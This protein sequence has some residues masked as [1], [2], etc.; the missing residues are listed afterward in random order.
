MANN[1]NQIHEASLSWEEQLAMKLC[2]AAGTMMCVY[3]FCGIGVGALVGVLTGNTFLALL[4]G[5]VS[6]NFIQL[7]F[8]P[9]LQL[10]QNLQQ[11][12]SEFLAEEH[13][14]LAKFTETETEAIH[15]KLDKLL[16][17]VPTT[18]VNYRRKRVK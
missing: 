11:R 15:Y 5:A 2:N 4:F 8:L 12:H 13:Y 1:V 18:K 10:G 17:V 7:V 3:I 9:L 6:S 14:R 16:G